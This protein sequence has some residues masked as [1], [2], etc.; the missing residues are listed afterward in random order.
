MNVTAYLR[1]IGHSGPISPTLETL[2]IIHRAHLETVPFE[3]LDISLG[4][5]IVLDQDRFVRKIVE[6]NRGG[7]CY[8]LNGAFAALL[9]EMGYQVTLLS[10]RAPLKDESPG[11]EF[12]HL[13]LRVD[14]EQPWLADVGFG[15]CFLEP[16]LLKPGIE[17]KQ[18]QGALRVREEGDSLSVER[19]Q[20][21]GSWKTEYL[22]TLTPRRL[23]EFADMCHFH[24]TSPES[25]FTQNRLCTR[26]TSN[27]RVTLSDMKLIVTKNGNRQELILGSEEEWRMVLNQNFGLILPTY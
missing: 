3:N 27:G 8:E 24:Q 26:S 21:D 2:R 9:R 10:A 14:L 15:E 16:L 19:Q 12:D 11:P 4:R 1:R 13:A 22:F 18:E 7:F 23:E 20:P 25:H 17:Q 6:E 5:P